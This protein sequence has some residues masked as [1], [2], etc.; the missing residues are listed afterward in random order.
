MVWLQNEVE[1]KV[2]GAII[3]K[4]KGA[5]LGQVCVKGKE[6]MEA[7]KRGMRLEKRKPH[8]YYSE[9]KTTLR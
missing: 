3:K 6:S 1:E 2:T 7:G 9:K 5:K 8:Q 4:C